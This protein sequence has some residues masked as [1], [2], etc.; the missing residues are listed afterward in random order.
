MVDDEEVAAAEAALARARHAS[1]VAA[2][3]CFSNEHDHE[4]YRAYVV[5]LSA[6]IEA[7]ALVRRLRGPGAMVDAS[8]RR[9]RA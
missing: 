2:S 5:A 1:R 3:V 6:E 9:A 4:A 8:A 7:E